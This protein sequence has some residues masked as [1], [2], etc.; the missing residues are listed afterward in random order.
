MLANTKDS[1]SMVSNKNIFLRL[2]L[3]KHNL[4]LEKIKNKN[5]D[6]LDS[7]SNS[8]IVM[9][10]EDSYRQN[11]ALLEKMRLEKNKSDKIMDNNNQKIIENLLYSSKTTEMSNCNIEKAMKANKNSKKEKIILNKKVNQNKNAKKNKCTINKN[12]K[13]I[14]LENNLKIKFNTTTNSKIIKKIDLNN[15]KSSNNKLFY[16]NQNLIK[17]YKQIPLNSNKTYETALTTNLKK[18]KSNASKI[19]KNKSNKLN[20]SY[21]L[22]NN[23]S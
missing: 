12:K 19:V 1:L 10:N 20:F 15:N 11:K 17:D 6:S 13:N 2:Q 16:E 4:E 23:N 21:L 14:H 3:D 5:D 18:Y 7:K 22:L 8:S 9:I